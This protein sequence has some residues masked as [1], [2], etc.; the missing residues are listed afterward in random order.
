M[1]STI[2]LDNIARSIA[3]VSDTHVGSSLAVWPDRK[4][5]T[6]EGNDLTASRSEAQ[7]KLS[8]YW[9]NYLARCKEFNVDTVIHLGDM[10]QGC[11]P[12]EG[13][14]LTITPD[15]EY[16]KDAA[17][18]LLQPLVQDR[19]LHV[20]SGSKYHQ[21]L[22]TK[23]HRDMTHRLGKYAREA[24]FHGPV[25]NLLFRGTKKIANIAHAAT[26]ALIYPSTVLD[27]ERVYLKLAEAQNKI[28]KIDYFIRGH[29][30]YYFHLDYPDMHIIQCPGWQVWYPL[31]DKVRLY[32]KTQPDIG[33]LIL[34][35]DKQNRTI[36][37]HFLYP[38]P[39]VM[40]SLMEA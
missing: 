31:G 7:I 8:M 25:R 23:I 39:N 34:L 24:Y 4:I 38:C 20:V 26:S 2:N 15:I 33:G 16:Q 14:R 30:H 12:K 11:N 17:E 21:S 28:P 10:C 1:T 36:L 13:G 40:D 3:I 18:A 6:A 29:L 22:D 9:K 35:I 27:R 19:I 37:L 32:G 5:F